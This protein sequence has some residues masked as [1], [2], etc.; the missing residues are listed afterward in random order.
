[1]Q[2]VKLFTPSSLIAKLA[3]VNRN[4]AFRQMADVITKDLN[5]RNSGLKEDEVFNEVIMHEEIS[6]TLARNG[7]AFP[8]VHVSR[9]ESVGICIATLEKP[10]YFSNNLE[11][12]IIVMTV[13]PQNRT[14]IGLKIM[15][16]VSRFLKD[17]DNRA[18][19]LAAQSPLE[20]YMLF[21]QADLSVD[22]PICAAD[23]MRPPRW[24]VHPDAPLEEVTRVMYE[25]NQR[26]LPVVDDYLHILGIITTETLF[27][28]GMPDFFTKLKSISFIA[29]FD[30]FEKYFEEEVKSLAKDVMEPAVTISPNYTILEIVFDLVVRHIPRLFVVDENKRWIGTVGH[31]TVLDNIIRY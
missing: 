26:D 27:T 29:E 3:V 11:A 9:L 4:E 19:M 8:H 20:L 16:T 25:T 31:S 10:V 30:P 17:D 14:E 2:L 15:A 21:E 22:T 23:V 5:D 7:V 24:F 28:L 1:M 13:L 12:E 18:K 6:P